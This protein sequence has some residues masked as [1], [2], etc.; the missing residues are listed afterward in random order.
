MPIGGEQREVERLFTKH[1]I[2]LTD[3]Q[4][5]PIPTAFYLFSDGFHD[6]FGQENNKKFGSRKLKEFLLQIHHQSALAQK[7]LL[8][9]AFEQW[10]G[11]TN[12]IDD[13][14]VIGARI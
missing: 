2:V 14:L 4:G 1:T 12:Q 7:H 3:E 5:F 11:S 8:Q 6:Q 13:V 9:Q 10:K